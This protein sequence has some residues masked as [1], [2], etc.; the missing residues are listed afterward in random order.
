[1]MRGKGHGQRG[2]TLLELLVAFAIMALSLGML[3]RAMG[4][5]ARSV[6]DVDR[7]QRA[8][9]LAQSLLALRDAVPEQG[10]NQAGDSAGYQWRIA[11]APYATEFNGPN[12]PPLH[13]VSITISWSD[14]TRPRS[15]ELSTLRPQ[16]RLP[17]PGRP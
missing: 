13:E 10:W 2:L 16:R 15:F 5:S 6:A 9:V 4:G 3:Y 12:I 7:Y 17:E 11:S 1:M 8:V 14:G